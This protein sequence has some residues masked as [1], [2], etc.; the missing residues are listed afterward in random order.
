M[1][2]TANTRQDFCTKTFKLSKS[3]EIQWF[4]TTGIVQLPGRR[5][6]KLEV[7]DEGHHDHLTALVVTIAHKDTGVIDRKTFNF[8]DYLKTRSDTRKDV[9]T[10]FYIWSEGRGGSFDWY[11]STP[12]DLG[13]LTYPIEAY[14]QAWE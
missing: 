5:I 1:S 3:R 9:E 7:V 6:A 11:I 10:N 2:R 13:E 4:D 14:I 8:N 12:K